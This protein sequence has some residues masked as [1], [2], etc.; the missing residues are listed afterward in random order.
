MLYKVDKPTIDNNR[1]AASFR[2]G[3]A[4][5]NR[6]ASVQS[7]VAL[8]L[9]EL[10]Q[11]LCGAQSF[12][13]AFEF[14][15]GTGGLTQHLVKQFQIDSFYAND[16]VA[17]CASQIETIAPSATFLPGAVQNIDL[18]GDLDLIA[19]SSA[20]QWI[21]AF[22]EFLPRLANELNI[23]GWLAISG[24]G[25]RHFHELQ[26]LGSR[27]AAPSYASET[28]LAEMLPRFMET[29]FV[30]SAEISLE[31]GALAPLLRH[32]RET[33]V[34]GRADGQLTKANFKQFEKDYFARFAVGD[35][36]PLTYQPVWLVAQ[37]TA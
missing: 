20:I 1:I 11:Q 22:D 34:N 26:E 31:F 19:S 2:R 8:Q 10:L 36:I 4:S 27:A 9:A 16:L 32:L 13:R 25:P 6:S 21:D 14:G 12:S 30:S 15:C 24:F 3:L 7:Q 29:K 23:G 37:R 18:P 35:K 28:D 5:Y 33:G 17:E